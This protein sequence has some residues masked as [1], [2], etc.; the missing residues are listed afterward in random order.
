[1]H[2]PHRAY[3]LSMPVDTLKI[4][5]FSSWMLP[6][7]WKPMFC[8]YLSSIVCSTQCN[9]FRTAKNAYFCH[10]PEGICKRKVNNGNTRR[11]WEIC[12]ELIIKTP[13]RCHWR[14]SGAFIINFTFTECSGVSIVDFKQV[15][16][17]W[18][19]VHCAGGFR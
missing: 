6:C 3:N 15:N 12:S 19:K 7:R 10:S 17:E 11:V 13:K 4:H 2:D 9:L 14:R 18:E 5:Y 8:S 16:A 1:M